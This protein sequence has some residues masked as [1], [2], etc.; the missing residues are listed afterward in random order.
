M[1]VVMEQ[2]VQEEAAMTKEGIAALLGWPSPPKDITDLVQEFR[3]IEPI[4]RKRNSIVWH[5][6]QLLYDVNERGRMLAKAWGLEDLTDTP[7]DNWRIYL[8]ILDTFRRKARA[9]MSGARV[10]V[11]VSHYYPGPEDQPRVD[12]CEAFMRMYRD[13]RNALYTKMGYSLSLD[14]AVREVAQIDG[15]VYLYLAPDPQNPAM[16]LRTELWDCTEVFP[17]WGSGTIERVYRLTTQ[18]AGLL[19][20][21]YPQAELPTDDYQNVKVLLYLDK[22][23]MAVI[24]YDTSDWLLPPTPHWLGCVP[25]VY[26]AYNGAPFA[27]SD[28]GEAALEEIE[29]FRGVSAY[30]HVQGLVEALRDLYS[31]AIDQTTRAAAGKFLTTLP[32]VGF[33]GNDRIE[34]IDD[35]PG[36]A[37]V[38]A[39]TTVQQVVNKASLP[40]LE[41]MIQRLLNDIY[42]ALWN[43]DSR[44][45][46]EVALERIMAT[47]EQLQYFQPYW[48]QTDRHLKEELELALKLW[49]T[50]RQQFPDAFPPIVVVQ[51]AQRGPDDYAQLDWYHI[52]SYL[53]ASVSSQT[54]S[55]IELLQK[56]QVSAQLKAAGIFPIRYIHERF[57][58]VDDPDEIE[59]QLEEDLARTSP[60]LQRGMA[61]VL[62][63]KQLRR[64]LA[65]AERAGDQMLIMILQ[66]EL[67][68]I[69]MQYQQGPPAPSPTQ[70]QEQPMPPEVSGMLGALQQNPALGEE[71]LLQ[72]ALAAEQGDLGPNPRTWASPQMPSS[73]PEIDYS[74]R[75]DAEMGVRTW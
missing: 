19:R 1:E 30:Y 59:R 22:A 43:L 33:T 7:L 51:R 31:A 8:P 42:N 18:R 64:E 24:N 58:D 47:R 70:Q 55:D 41:V 4:F 44:Q 71:A 20:S 25:L 10:R 73:S 57:M 16:P 49:R 13:H 50:M 66:R 27:R 61:A 39:G 68:A 36:A 5:I 63:V 35:T 32:E 75:L 67:E 21:L 26:T 28:V 14:E 74:R 40:A 46:H 12:L 56:G 53:C 65:E 60:L 72:A 17:V 48:D 15:H 52:P 9:I 2:A 69:M 54:S 29:A 11:R 23:W 45:G 34:P 62:A 38:P 37:V 6:R 3:R